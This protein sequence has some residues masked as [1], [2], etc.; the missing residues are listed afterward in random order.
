MIR[1]PVASTSVVS[2]GYCGAR[3]IL[4]IEFVHGGVYAYL[5][6]PEAEHCA[7]ISAPSK[8]R[9]VNRTI[10]ARYAFFCVGRRR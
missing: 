9:Y 8:G 10:K 3:N 5:D 6:V 7:L 1:E 2:I 4:E